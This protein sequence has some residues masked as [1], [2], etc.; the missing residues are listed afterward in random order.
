MSY[1]L[2]MQAKQKD[3]QTKLLVAL[4]LS[5]L[6]LFILAYF[7][8]PPYWEMSCTGDRFEC[9]FIQP[10]VEGIAKSI[11]LVFLIGSLFLFWIPSVS[12]ILESIFSRKTLSM[13]LFWKG[14]VI[15]IILI[16]GIYLVYATYLFIELN[17]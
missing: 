4:M 1:N 11:G 17:S 2:A 5:L 3:K 16:Q 14:M 10:G 15:S 9:E 8:Y 6:A 12:L 7:L 13:T